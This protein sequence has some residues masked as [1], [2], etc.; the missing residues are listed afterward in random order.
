MLLKEVILKLL[1][2]EVNKI[3][4][5]QQQ[6]RIIE[7]RLRS[8][9]IK[10]A[11]KK[12]VSDLSRDLVVEHLV[13]DVYDVYHGRYQR[14]YDMGGLAD[15]DNILTTMINDVTLKIEDVRRDEKTNRLVA[16]VVEYGYGYWTEELDDSIGKRPFIE[17][18]AKELRKGKARDA[19][20]KGLLRQ[21]LN[22][23]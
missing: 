1:L 16:P 23:K 5:L 12:E 2:R 8:K 7:N 4:S 15:E 11:M 20:K 14:D 17:N 3:P 6:L 22:V 18:T 9:Y 19:L 21:G 13:N 10:D